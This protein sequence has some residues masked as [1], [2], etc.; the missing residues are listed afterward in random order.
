MS[1]Q[2]KIIA[3]GDSWFDYPEILLTGGGIPPHVGRLLGTS[4]Q[5]FAHHGFGTED[6]LSIRKRKEIEEALP[7]TDILLFSGGGND[8]AGD[9]FCLWLND[10][11]DGDITKALSWDR[12]NKALDLTI[13]DYDDLADL[14]T[15]IVPECIIVTHSYDF[16]PTTQ[17]GVGVCGQG[18]WLQPS[19]AYCGWNKLEDQQGIVKMA[20]QGLDQRLIEWCSKDP[21]HRMHIAT[22][23]MLLPT[24]W[25]NEL[26]PNRSGF[27]KLG[28]LYY[29]VLNP[30]VSKILARNVQQV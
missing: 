21:A 27:T 17:F 10:N 1:K 18:P 16:P 12:L 14:V 9:Q 23:G 3:H 29:N 7:G 11:K 19:L 4:I 5:N 26:H 22:Q 2:I 13:A 20:L 6:M 24:D 25:G 8:I 28:Q 30:I 15:S